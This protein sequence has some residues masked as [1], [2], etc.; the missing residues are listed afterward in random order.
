MTKMPIVKAFYRTIRY[1]LGSVCV[2]GFLLAVVRMIRVIMWSIKKQAQGI[3][4]VPFM[5]FAFYCADCCLRCLE[6]IVKYINRQAYIMI[7]I[8]GKGFCCSAFQV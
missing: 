6:G 2:G 5:G 1:H 8:D 3:K 7:A 4:K